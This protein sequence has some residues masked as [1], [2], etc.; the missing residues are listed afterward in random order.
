MVSGTLQYIRNWKSLL[1]KLVD[2]NNDFF[3]LTRF[4]TGEMP[5]FTTIQSIVMSYGP[6]KG[7]YVGRYLPY[8]HKQKRNHSFLRQQDYEVCYDIF[9]PITVRIC[10]CCR[11]HFVMRVSGL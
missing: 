5:T 2:L 11:S 6:H 4:S 9:T 3:V 1:R 8:L 7:K 10:V